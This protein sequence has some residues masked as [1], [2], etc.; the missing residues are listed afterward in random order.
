VLESR[1]GWGPPASQDF[2]HHLEITET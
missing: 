2:R 1:D